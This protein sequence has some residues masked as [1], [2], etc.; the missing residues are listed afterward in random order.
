M[1]D[2]FKI[3][4]LLML[5]VFLPVFTGCLSSGSQTSSSISP[6]TP[7]KE[8]ARIL[9]SW[10]QTSPVFVPTSKGSLMSAEET[11]GNYISFKDLSGEVWTLKIEDILYVT[12]GNA[13]VTTYYYSINAEQG[14]LKIV[15]NMIK[16]QG[17]WY[18][19]DITI[20][21]LPIVVVTGTGIKGVISDNVN[22][23]PVEGALIEAY[24]QTTGTLAGSTV[25]GA[26]G[27]YSITDLAPGNYY[28]VVARDGYSPYTISGIVVN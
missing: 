22:N 3:A 2:R 8:V 23:A 10:Q 27:F 19:D 12:E 11:S 25:T 18:V 1:P 15:F 20:E 5:L 7:E 13:I 9:Q 16:D 26:D 6:E 21:A 4:A 28:I 14:N 17:F 24:E